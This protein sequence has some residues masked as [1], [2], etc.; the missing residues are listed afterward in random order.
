M[1]PAAGSGWLT[2]GSRLAHGW[3]WSTPASADPPWPRRDHTRVPGLEGAVGLATLLIGQAN[4]ADAIQQWGKS[5]LH[6]DEM[7]NMEDA[8]KMKRLVTAEGRVHRQL[9]VLVVAELLGRAVGVR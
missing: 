4:A 8:M 9:G 5:N 7:H 6:A 3:L 1:P 2:G